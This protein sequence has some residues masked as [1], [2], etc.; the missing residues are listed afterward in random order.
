[1]SGA[2]ELPWASASELAL[3]I[4]RRELSPVE[5]VDACIARIEA[6]NPSLNALRLPRLRRCPQGAPGRPSRR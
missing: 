4:R 6:R 2:D 3:R 5:V 1:M